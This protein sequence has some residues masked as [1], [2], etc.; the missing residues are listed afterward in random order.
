MIYL[1]NKTFMSVLQVLYWYLANSEPICHLK[2]V[3]DA[4]IC[5]ILLVLE[6]HLSN[7]LAKK[8]LPEW[9][10]LELCRTIFILYDHGWTDD[11][12]GWRRFYFTYFLQLI[13]KW[14][15]VHIDF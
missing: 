1:D 12:N 2:C 7:N 11:M 6:T 3:F 13:S 8:G 15:Q 5:K 14:K 10:F 9:Q 4:L